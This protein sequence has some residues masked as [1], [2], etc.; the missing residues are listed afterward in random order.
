LAQR[1]K[2]ARIFALFKTYT[3]ERAWKAIGDRLQ[4]PHYLSRVDHNRKIRNKKH[5]TD[6]RKYSFVNKTIQLWNQLPADALGT[7]PCKPSIFRKRVRKVISE[8]K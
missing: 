3:G 5:R 6:F 2:I 7:F 1:R 4:R 8:V